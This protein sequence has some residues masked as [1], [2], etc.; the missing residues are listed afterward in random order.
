L[1]DVYEGAPTIITA[2]FAI[3]PKL[4]L[5]VVILRLFGLIFHSIVSSIMPLI[6]I[7]SLI[8]LVVAAFV[9]LFQQ[10][11]KRFFAYSSIGHVGYILIGVVIGSLEGFQGV[12]I[13]LLI[14]LITSIFVWVLILALEEEIGG[15]SIYFT[16]LINL[17]T[18]H[19]LLAGGFIFVIFS[20]AGVPPLIGFFAKI[21]VFY[22]ALNGG[23]FFI[24]IIGILLS[25]IG[26]FYYIRFI[27]IIYFESVNII[28]SYRSIA[29]V[30]GRRLAFSR[31][32][33][34]C[35]VLDPDFLVT[36]SRLFGITI[37]T[38]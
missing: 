34:C 26:A 31:I 25:C 33:I 9:A 35:F 8:S 15:Q 24:A 27:K 21:I 4:I 36:T 3:V 11:L 5:M 37:Y 23:Y 29:A 32:V 1:P 38:P 30:K 7:C 19:T 10:R 14:Y 13:Y 20:I 17:G 22:A 16:D 18:T 12:F 2:F 6:R 28:F